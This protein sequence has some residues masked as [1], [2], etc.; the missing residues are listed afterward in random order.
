MAKKKVGTVRGVTLKAGGLLTTGQVARS[1][2][3]D[4]ST[5]QKRAAKMDGVQYIGGRY[6]L[7]PAQAE[8]VAEALRNPSKRGPKAVEVEKQAA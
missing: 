3:V 5:V 8:A 1:L 2:G 7:T 4:P 6:L